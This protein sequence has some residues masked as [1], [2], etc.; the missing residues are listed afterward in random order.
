MT[1]LI[2][3]FCFGGILT[4]HG[5]ILYFQDLDLRVEHFHGFSAHGDGGHYHYD[6]TPNDVAYSAYF[7]VAE[8]MFRIDR[9]RETHTIG[10]D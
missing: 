2:L 5:M 6:T 3:P 9:P 10:R 4:E 8:F 7:N 1:L